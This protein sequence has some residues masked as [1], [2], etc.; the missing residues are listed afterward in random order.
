MSKGPQKITTATDKEMMYTM[1]KS[2]TTLKAIAEQFGLAYI[3]LKKYKKDG[4]WDERKELD[5][6]KETNL[7]T[8]GPGALG[9][10]AYTKI[11]RSCFVLAER[12][13]QRIVKG[14]E[15]INPGLLKV[16]TECIDKLQRLHLFSESG[17]VTKSET[18]NLNVKVNYKEMAKLYKEAKEKGEQYDS[19]KH[20]KDVINATYED[21]DG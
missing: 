4:K 14:G 6:A 19:G 5:V 10:E 16:L 3:T 11:L 1:Y 8:S 2:G 13:E 17:G 7:T 12:T 15:D 9:K 20:L 18:K 21:N